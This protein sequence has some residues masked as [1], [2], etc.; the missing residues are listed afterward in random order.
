MVYPINVYDTSFEP[1]KRVFMKCVYVWINDNIQ[2]PFYVGCGTR[3]RAAKTYEGSRTKSFLE[4]YNNNKC[5]YEILY[6][7]LS[8]AE[9][10]DLE[11][12]T[13]NQY[14]QMGYNLTNQTNGGEMRQYGEW[15]K[16]MR[17]EYSERM[18][19]KN[20]PNYGHHWTSEM[21]EN[22][23]RVRIEKGIAKG[24]LNPRSTPVM[25]V[26]TGEIFQCKRDATGF[27]GVKD[28]S[29]SISFCIKNPKRVA[30][31]GKYHFVPEN[32]FEELDNKEKR[33]EWLKRIMS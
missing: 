14:R 26:E 22:L 24:S 4:V 31:K 1:S 30:G 25:C 23:S 21:K 18:K 6:D 15:T 5:H 29:S 2:Q 20:N 11:R 27:L 32:M 17:T 10:A 28:A 16:E 3:S 13:I 9:A 7:N 33:Q 8:N 12:K 19:G